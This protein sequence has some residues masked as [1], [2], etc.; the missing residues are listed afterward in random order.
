MVFSTFGKNRTVLG[1]IS[2][3]VSITENPSKEKSEIEFYT[4]PARVRPI[5]YLKEIK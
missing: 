2:L 4:T 5:N 3:L 1:H